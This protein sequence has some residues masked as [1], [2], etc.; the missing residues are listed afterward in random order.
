MNVFTTLNGTHVN[1]DAVVSISELRWNYDIGYPVRGY[2]NYTTVFNGQPVKLELSFDHGHSLG[3]SR[4]VR[5]EKDQRFR[6]ASEKEYRRLL[7]Q[8]KSKEV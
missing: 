7:K 3:D 5:K 6:K 2:I 8:W 1:L 4:E